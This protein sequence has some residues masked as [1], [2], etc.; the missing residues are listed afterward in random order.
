MMPASPSPVP[1]RSIGIAGRVSALIIAFVMLAEV[2]I[3]VPSIASFRNGWLHDRLTASYTAALVFEAAPDGS[4][5][6]D[7]TRDVLQSIG[8]M[9]LAIRIH[10]ARRLLAVTEMPPMV[11]ESVDLRKPSAVGDI[12]AAFRSLLARD[13]RTLNVIG[14]APMGGDS[15]EFTISETALRQ[16]MLDYSVNI[17]LL[18]L[19][20]SAVVGS[21]ALLAMNAL[22]LKPVRGLTS[23]LIGFGAD[24]DNASHIIR[25]SGRRD[26]I[27][28]AE[29]ELGRMQRALARELAQRKHLAALGLAVAKINHDLRN[30]LSSA[31]LLS[32]RLAAST[33][34][35]AKTLSPRLVATLDR[36]IAFC[37][38]TLAYGRS[39][40]EPPVIRPFV[41]AAVVDDAAATVAPLSGMDM[42]IDNRIAPD[43]TIEADP[44]LMFRVFANL[45]RNSMDA[46]KAKGSGDDAPSIEID[47]RREAGMVIIDIADNGPGVPEA[48]RAHLFKPFQTT[49]SAGGSGLGLA[50]AADIVR[51]HGGTLRLVTGED[52]PGLR[53]ANFRIALPIAGAQ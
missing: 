42:V 29:V 25:P 53:G 39:A 4:L 12:V 47:A 50:I 18:S 41:L 16:A 7:L 49:S 32:D 27:G 46:L 15:V 51:A 9:T 24:P 22:V 36:A 3:Y 14:A 45:L 30:M 48:A 1:A 26:E 19:V 43:W 23:S 52:W 37:Q 11:D 31:Q 35:V 34:P 5:P 8:A 33:D 6:P 44:D 38:S 20:I 28:E 40:S 21:L 17:L 13:G 2:A 10:N